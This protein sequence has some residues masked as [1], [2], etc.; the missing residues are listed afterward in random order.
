MAWAWT[1][2][3]DGT[4]LARDVRAGGRWCER[5]GLGAEVLLL[6][7]LGSAEWEVVLEVMARLPELVNEKLMLKF[8]SKYPI[9][10]AAPS[11]VKSRSGRTG[12][13]L[14]TLALGRSWCIPTTSWGTRLMVPWTKNVDSRELGCVF[15][16]GSKPVPRLERRL[17]WAK[18][19]E[20]VCEEDGPSPGPTSLLDI[21]G[22]F[23]VSF[24]KLPESRR[25]ICE[26]E[27]AIFFRPLPTSPLRRRTV[28]AA[29][30][31]WAL[32]RVEKPLAGRPRDSKMPILSL[33]G[34]SCCFF[35][36]LS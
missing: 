25:Q 33:R 27:S 10:S 24:S 21:G 1:E 28:A 34:D 4:G 15:R 14:G 36:S 7:W 22:V 8:C 26:P 23:W 35:G 2:W 12:D 17:F 29:L 3:M 19:P 31:D 6:S 20:K 30:E 11:T 32:A 9:M 18:W 16:R 5:S 13:G